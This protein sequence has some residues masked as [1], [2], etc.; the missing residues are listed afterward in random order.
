MK[1]YKIQNEFGQDITTI[2]TVTVK[3]GKIRVIDEF[4]IDITSIVKIVKL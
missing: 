3:A 4:G 2:V 1:T